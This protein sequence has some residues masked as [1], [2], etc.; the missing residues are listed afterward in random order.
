M[1]CLVVYA[2]VARC[3]VDGDYSDL[4]CGFPLYF[5]S[6]SALLRSKAA[7][8]SLPKRSPWSRPRRSPEFVQCLERSIPTPC[9]WCPSARQS[10]IY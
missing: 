8:A 7:L 5:F 2:T 1:N 10:T 9:A 4:N 6:L 3:D